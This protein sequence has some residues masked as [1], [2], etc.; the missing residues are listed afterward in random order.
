[1]ERYKLIVISN[2][3]M[4]IED[5]SV[6]NQ[7]DANETGNG[8]NLAGVKYFPNFKYSKLGD[9]KNMTRIKTDRVLTLN[10]IHMNISKN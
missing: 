5:H 2:K 4:R 9:R 8:Q 6:V 10:K 3:D 7:I 1:M